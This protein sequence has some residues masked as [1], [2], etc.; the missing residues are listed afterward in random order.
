MRMKIKKNMLQRDKKIKLKSEQKWYCISQLGQTQRALNN[1][2][3]YRNENKKHT[4]TK[5][6]YV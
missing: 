6:I 4:V 1:N 5:I 2:G 3:I